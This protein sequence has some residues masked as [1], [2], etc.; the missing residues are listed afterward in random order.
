MNINIRARLIAVFGLGTVAGAIF[1]YQDSTVRL[2]RPD[3]LAAQ[4]LRYDKM[5]MGPRS[6]IGAI[7]ACVG[8]VC[9]AAAIYEVVVFAVRKVMDMIDQTTNCDRK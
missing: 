5:H 1:Y 6:I 8:I 7:V 9:I 2:T 3:F 4:A